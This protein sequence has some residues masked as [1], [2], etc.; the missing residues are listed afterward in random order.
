MERREENNENWGGRKS[1]MK[2]KEKKNGGT[3]I[4]KGCKAFFLIN[5]NNNENPDLDKIKCESIGYYK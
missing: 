4:V 1:R 2:R 5:R 3:Q